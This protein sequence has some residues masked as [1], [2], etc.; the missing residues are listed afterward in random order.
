PIDPQEGGDL[1][2]QFSVAHA[3]NDASKLAKHQHQRHHPRVAKLQSRRSLTVFGHGRLQHTLDAA[4]AQATVLADT[5]D[6]GRRWL[7]WWPSS[8]REGR[9]SIP[10]LTAKSPGSWKVP[11][12]RRP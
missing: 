8:L 5:L 11:S 9:F 2:A 4:G 1:P 12:V 3:L 6:F 7:I 10:L